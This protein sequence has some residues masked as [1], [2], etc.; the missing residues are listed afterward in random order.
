MGDSHRV[1]A[2]T[3]SERYANP[4]KKGK[5]EFGVFCRSLYV[6]ICVGVG[7]QEGVSG[8]LWARVDGGMREKGVLLC[9][10]APQ[11]QVSWGGDGR[12]RSISVPCVS[13]DA[14]GLVHTHKEGEGGSEM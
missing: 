5:K 8:W 10:L 13:A 4:V 6:C 7:V 3:A 11:G 14:A 2:Q 12:R 9:P 1:L